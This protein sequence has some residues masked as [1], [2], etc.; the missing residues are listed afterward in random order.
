[1]HINQFSFAGGQIDRNLIGRRDLAKYYNSA[2]KIE[3]FI[4]KR[5]G[6]LRKREGFANFATE[7]T[8]P[9]GIVRVI[10]FYKSERESGQCVAFSVR[11]AIQ[12]FDIHN[13]KL[14]VTIS[15]TGYNTE[16]II[17]ALEYVQS[18]D[19][20]FI[21][22]RDVP[23]KRLVRKGDTFTLET[24]VF[25]SLDTTHKPVLTVD[26]TNWTKADSSKTR[27]I[28]YR[29]SEIVGGKEVRASDAVAVS[30]PFPPA[31]GSYSK[32]NITRTDTDEDFEG[33]NIYR[34]DGSGWGYIGTT[35]NAD[36]KEEQEQEQTPVSM[37]FSPWAEDGSDAWRTQ[38]T[39]GGVLEKKRRPMRLVVNLYPESP[40]GDTPFSIEATVTM[41]DKTHKEVI[42]K[43]GPTPSFVL[44]G[45]FLSSSTEDIRVELRII[46]G[47]ESVREPV[48][49]LL[50]YSESEGEVSGKDTFTDDYIQLDY[51]QSIPEY[52][53]P[54]EGEGN[55]PGCVCLYQQRMVWASTHNNPSMF[56]MSVPGDLNNF[57]VHKNI[58]DDDS[59]NAALP[60]TRGP[61]ILHMVAHKALLMF[62]EN[63]E[64]VV[65]ARGDGSLSYKTIASEQQSYTGSSERVRPLLC[66]NAVLF[67]DRAGSSVRE[68]KYDYALD[69]MSGRDIS[70]LNSEAI[71]EHGGIVDWCYQMFPESL[72]WCAMGDGTLAILTY[73]PEQDVYAWSAAGLSGGFSAKSIACTDEPTYGRLVAVVSSEASGA[74]EKI[75]VSDIG[76]H[77]DTVGEDT[78]PIV[79]VLDTVIPDNGGNYEPNM[80]RLISAKVR[81][82][83]LDGI[84]IEALS[85]DGE[86]LDI[87]VPLDANR[88]IR[89]G[90]ADTQIMSDWCRDPSLHIVDKSSNATEIQNLTVT[91][92]VSDTP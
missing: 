46:S 88:K 7:G 2:F 31:Q 32:L 65:M 68:Y 33:Y 87:A 26:T 66:G 90:F 1:M 5:N 28:Y 36:W 9:S 51:S 91:L 62:C 27:T 53:Q 45:T 44:S 82:I 73:L 85:E 81:G 48:T 52:R 43:P 75:F 29:A 16:A 40:S 34:N 55:Y 78:Y 21:A 35:T 84:K 92:D 20:I 56:W 59:I 10:P 8:T 58:Q 86:A 42:E 61:K 79:A 47:Y 64:C 39:L 13:P 67:V 74:G 25:D 6:V 23:P 63:S 69:A 30:V 49:A 80:K 70:V 41:G 12:I 4:V 37:N 22:S 76:T 17:L 83:H 38:S 3:N 60:L 19:T 54:F 11:G 24:I 71:V 15:N 50:Y 18:G 72:V 57:S 77:E 89:L 14:N